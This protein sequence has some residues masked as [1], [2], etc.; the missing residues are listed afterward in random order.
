[1]SNESG[2]LSCAHNR[3]PGRVTRDDN[4]EEEIVLANTPACADEF[5]LLSTECNQKH[6]DPLGRNTDLT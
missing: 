1:M 3:I 2:N 4:E 6:S 5:N